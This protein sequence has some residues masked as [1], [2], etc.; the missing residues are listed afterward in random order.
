MLT[1]AS[2][3]CVSVAARSESARAQRQASAQLSSQAK[4]A[5]VVVV[6]RSARGQGS[7]PEAAGLGS[8]RGGRTRARTRRASPVRLAAPRLRTRAGSH[9][10]RLRRG[11]GAVRV[12][13]GEEARGIGGD[14]SGVLARRTS[15]GGQRG[16]RARAEAGAPERLKRASTRPVHLAPR[17]AAPVPREA[18]DSCCG[19]C[20]PLRGAATGRGSAW[21][22]ERARA[23]GAS[24]MSGLARTQARECRTMGGRA[25]LALESSHLA[26]PR[27]Q[28]W[29]P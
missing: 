10:E 4:L 29:S 28:A 16:A 19:V 6:V 3:S 22:G 21:G 12:G 9:D 23:G 18:N 7:G 25:H 1:A 20:A 15:T 27:Q 17:G 2:L 13:P 11:A 24:D 5:R 26:L 8:R 14:P